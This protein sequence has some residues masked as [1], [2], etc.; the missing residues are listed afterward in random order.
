MLTKDIVEP[1]TTLIMQKIFVLLAGMIVFTACDKDDVASPNFNMDGYWSVL[2]PVFTSV[3]ANSTADQ[4]HLFKGTNGFFS[5]SFLKTTDFSNPLTRPRNDSIIGFHQIVGNELQIP[6]VAPAL[7][8]LPS[9]NNLLSEG[10][11]E[12]VFTRY[13]VLRR[14]ALDGKVVD[15]RTDTIR[16][17][18]V[19]D[20]VKIAYFDT[21]LKRYYP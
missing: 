1:K 18:R 4:Y 13:L 14:S 17:I 12:K 6:I 7:N 15:S 9:A 10:Q 11:N 3:S 8:N 20:A 19:T 5:Y 16:Y 21:Y 2:D